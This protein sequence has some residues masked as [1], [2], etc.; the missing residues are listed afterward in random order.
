MAAVEVPIKNGDANVKVRDPLIS[1]VLT[2]VTLGIYG[3]YW[4]YKV[5]EEMVNLGRA[6]GTTELGDNATTS[7]LALIPGGFIIVPPFVSFWNGSIRA[8]NAQRVA[9]IPEVGMLNNVLAFILMIIFSPAGIWYLQSELNKVWANETEG[10]AEA[11]TAGAQAGAPAPPPQPA[12]PQQ[13]PPPPPPA[14]GDQPPPPP[15]G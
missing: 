15:A 2:F 13:A 7:L 11:L 4:W 6:R 1:G 5:N 8:Q 12:Q 3:I 14:G 9:G 10:G